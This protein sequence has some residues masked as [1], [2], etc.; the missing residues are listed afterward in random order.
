MGRVYV[1]DQMFFSGLRETDLP[2]QL[3]QW[4]GIEASCERILNIRG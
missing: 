3:H 4:L 1:Q 2:K